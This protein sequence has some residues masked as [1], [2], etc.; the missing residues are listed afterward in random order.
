MDEL[1]RHSLSQ[2][3]NVTMNRICYSL[4]EMH[5]LAEYIRKL[6]E[7]VETNPARVVPVHD[8]EH[9]THRASGWRVR[10]S[11]EITA[12]FKVSVWSGWA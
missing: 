8:V 3:V 6:D 4:L 12:Q 5:H 9:V 11:H 10:N 7:L 2:S 1:S